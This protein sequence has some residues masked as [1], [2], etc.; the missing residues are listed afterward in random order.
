MTTVTTQISAIGL[1][2]SG[3]IA[4]VILGV[5]ELSLLDSLN[6]N[7]IPCIGSPLPTNTNFAFNDL[8][9]AGTEFSTLRV[10]EA[11]RIGFFATDGN[12]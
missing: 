10:T 12:S 2:L 8:I 11:F 3:N 1:S 7:G 5:E 6:D 4:T 9:A